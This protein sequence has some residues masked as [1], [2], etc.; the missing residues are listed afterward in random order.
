MYCVLPRLKCIP[1]LLFSLS[2]FFFARSAFS[3]ADIG[4]TVFLDQG[5]DESASV[6]D[7]YLPSIFQELKDGFA[8]SFRALG[9]VN[10]ANPSDSPINPGNIWQIPDYTLNLNLRPDFYLDFRTLNVIFKPRLNLQW[11]HWGEGPRSGDSKWEDDW[12][13]NE[14]LV[15]MRLYE[16]L[17]ASY[18]RENL[19]WGP[20]WLVSPSN[21][22]FRDNG[23][24][25]PTSEVP[26]LDFGR[27][28]W[29]P[30]SSWTGSFIANTGEG[31]Q[32]FI[33]EFKNTYAL[34]FDYTTYKKYASLIVSHRE[35]ERVRF[36]GFA[37]WTAS[38]AVLLYGEGALFK[39]SDYWYPLRSA[40]AQAG[41][42]PDLFFEE[43]NSIEGILLLGGTYTFE[44]GPSVTMEYV[45]NSPGLNNEQAESL[46]QL[47]ERGSGIF[48]DYQAINEA[49]KSR[50]ADPPSYNVKMLRKNYLML[51]YSYLQIRDVLNLIL[52]YTFNIDDSSSQLLPIVQYSLGDHSQLYLV[53]SQTFGSR[54]SE[55]RMLID[56]S[57]MFGIQY[58]F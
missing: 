5:Q 21:P 14:W 28:V 25:N 19:Q 41:V 38:D 26:G 10:T 31:T 1:F 15:R 27:L 42:N 50:N 57:V 22:F 20:S 51:Q 47:A 8:Y 33:G 13:V 53:G 36:G 11:R 39:G 40:A 6:S 2:L 24:S 35:G 44:A 34:K 12:F 46:F 29:M 4:Q 55:F 9:Y 18:G 58:T 30:D 52:R 54:D 16:G 7:E 32:N 49:L 37:G 45:F 23:Q 17:F 43:N 3:E 48:N 56:R